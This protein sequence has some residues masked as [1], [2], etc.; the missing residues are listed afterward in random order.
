MNETAYAWLALSAVL[1]LLS[2]TRPIWAVCFYLQTFFA[3]PQYWWWGKGGP[4]G[5]FR[6]N[7][8]AGIVLLLAVLLDVARS[9]REW[10][11]PRLKRVG[12]MALLVLLNL[13]L[14][15]VFLANDP[16]NSFKSYQLTAKFVLLFFLIVWSVRTVG[17]L[18]ILLLA[19]SVG[20]GYLGY[21]VTLN[22]RGHIVQS[23]LEGIGAPGAEASNQLASMLVTTLPI[24][25]GLFFIG[26]VREKAFAALT[27][28]LA[29]NVVILCNSRAA[30]LA[31]GAAGAVLVIAARGRARLWAAT[32]LALGGLAGFLLLGDERVIERFMTTFSKEEDRDRSATG[33]LDYWK[34]GLDMVADYPLGAG[35]YGFKETHGWKYTAKLP[36][37]YDIKSVHNGFINEMCEWGIQGLVLRLMW[38]G[39]AAWV[40][41]QTVV[42]R[43]LLGDPKH[44]FFA[45]CLIASQAAFLVTAMF[46]DFIESEWAIWSAAVAVAY[47]RLLGPYA[48]EIVE[49]PDAYYQQQ[50]EHNAPY[51][52]PHTV[53]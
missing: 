9:G 30:F 3:L 5:S 17:D 42:F 12:K 28:P 37:I 51:E 50:L 25:G 26:A 52:L 15:H 1:L 49:V 44:A 34:A 2:F 7:L 46:G 39:S 43:N 27:A 31:C 45:A 40:A 33:R 41:Y 4:I 21:E 48:E 19:F 10:F 53:A 6:W 47:S 29:L 22:K 8:L 24:V 18:K 32:A 11:D 38:L 20:L 13:S 14:V 23:R 16:E 35:G 36:E